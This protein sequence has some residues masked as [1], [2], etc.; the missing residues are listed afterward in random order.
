MA[1]VKRGVAAHRRH[2]KVLLQVK[3]HRGTRNRLYKRAHESMMRALQYAYRDRRNRKRA[4]RRLWIQRI[5][6]ASRLN[7]L[8]YSRLIQ[9]LTLAGVTV[10]RKMMA[11]LAVRDEEAFA[12]LVTVAR[13]SLP[14]TQA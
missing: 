8:T 12:A 11:D 10:D 13:Q 3:G 14:A 5:N 2:R 4:M 9:G 6:A 7:G 1:R